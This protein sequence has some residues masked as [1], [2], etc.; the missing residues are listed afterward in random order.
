MF[1]LRYKGIY[2]TG[3]LTSIGIDDG[4]MNSKDAAIWGN[5][6]L[7]PNHACC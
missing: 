7:I 1:V 3:S 4:W 6:K 2:E 5:V